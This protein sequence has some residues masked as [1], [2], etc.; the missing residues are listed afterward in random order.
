MECNPDISGLLLR[1]DTDTALQIK[2]N[3]GVRIYPT[4]RFFVVAKLAL[5]KVEQ[6]RPLQKNR[7]AL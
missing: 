2:A 3:V 4:R 5:L 6:A 7:D 1:C